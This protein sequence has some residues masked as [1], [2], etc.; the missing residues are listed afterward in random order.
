MTI[1]TSK[2]LKAPITTIK[3]ESYANLPSKFRRQ[4]SRFTIG[5]P[6]MGEA[7][8]AQAIQTRMYDLLQAMAIL[9]EWQV[10]NAVF[11]TACQ[12]AVFAYRH[13]PPRDESMRPSQKDDYYT[14]VKAI[15]KKQFGLIEMTCREM[16]PGED[17]PTT[18]GM[19]FS[20]A[21]DIQYAYDLLQ[22]VCDE[23]YACK[24]K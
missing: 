23:I 15:P 18:K 3:Q 11:F 22:K 24:S 9:D 7:V 5:D 16:T 12:E 21:P 8:V 10:G 1:T 20:L 4:H 17:N 13:M 14:F 6:G 19:L 2:P